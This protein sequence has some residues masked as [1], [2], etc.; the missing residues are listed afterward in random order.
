MSF[1]GGKLKLKGGSD[2]SG[3][4]KKKKK[5]KHS[6]DILASATDNKDNSELV[7]TGDAGGGTSTQQPI[8]EDRRTEAEKRFEAHLMKTEEQRLKKAASKSHR[9][10]IKELN[11]KLASTTEHFDLPRISHTN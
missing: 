7:T 11:E 1:V 3:V 5:S 6:N 10:R 8:V 2:L 9:E 4:K